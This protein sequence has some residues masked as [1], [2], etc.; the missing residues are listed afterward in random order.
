MTLEGAARRWN[1]YKSDAIQMGVLQLL[2]IVVCEWVKGALGLHLA[3]KK[4]IL[5]LACSV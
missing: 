4:M 3:L 2:C 5:L 1:S